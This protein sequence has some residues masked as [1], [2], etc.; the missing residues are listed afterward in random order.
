MKC[1]IK[2]SGPLAEIFD[3]SDDC[4]PIL[5][6][7]LQLLP[8]HKHNKRFQ[9]NQIRGFN[10]SKFLISRGVTANVIVENPSEHARLTIWT[11]KLANLRTDISADAIQGFVSSIGISYREPQLRGFQK[12]LQSH[13]ALLAA[14]CGT[15][16]TLLNLSV[17]Q[18]KKQKYG[19]SL[20][21]VVA[22]QSC[23]SEYINELDRFRGYFDL[24]INDTCGLPTKSVERLV[25]EN[26]CDIILLSVDSINLLS[27]QIVTLLQNFD[28]DTLLVVEEGH[29]IKNVESKRS[30]GVQRIAP[31]FDQVIVSTATPLPLGSKDLRGYIGLVGLPQPEAAYSYGIPASDYSFLK[32]VVFVS[33]EEDIP[34]A[35]LETKS[36]EYNDLQELNRRTIDEVQSELLNGHKVVIFTSTNAALETAYNL[37]PKIPR[38]V[39]SGSFYAESPHSENLVRGRC[40]NHQRK[41]IDAF[42]SDPTCKILIANYKVGSTGL[43]LQYSG[44]RMAFFY[45]IT[46]CGADFFQSK[47]RIRR[48]NVFP[49]EGFK[50]VYALPLD[51]KRRK[52]VNKQFL[53]LA[54]Q[55]ETLK[56]LKR[57]STRVL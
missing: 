12:I 26:E 24:T 1:N 8:I 18:F 56:Q 14:G 35:P 52:T 16:K 10:L 15:G 49:P 23:A 27:D 51:P 53:K 7:V 31:L 4:E 33:D 19:K 47:Y 3:W 29:S 46:N 25:D 6:S 17:S 44:A 21:L 38:T 28:G 42:N 20:T 55:R 22:P 30:Q 13:F 2:I 48:P 11:E 41:A 37:F 36:I 5:D 9:T 39:L 57:A 34:Y 50:Y 43:N 54:D 32:G 40:K 45:E